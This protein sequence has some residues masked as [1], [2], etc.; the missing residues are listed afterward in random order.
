[1]AKF[2]FQV[3]KL[4]CLNVPVGPRSLTPTKR[5]GVRTRTT[6]NFSGRLGDQESQAAHPSAIVWTRST[7][8]PRKKGENNPPRRAISHCHH[9]DEKEE[10][11]NNSFFLASCR[12]VVSTNAKRKTWQKAGERRG[13]EKN[14]WKRSARRNKTMPPLACKSTE[15]AK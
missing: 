2:Q 3:L 15:A 8:G 13:L 14:F 7:Q 5:P 6:F 11:L 1:M 4:E 9:L 10:Q 12:T